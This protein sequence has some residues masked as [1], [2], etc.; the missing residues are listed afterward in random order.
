MRK[1]LLLLLVFLTTNSFSQVSKILFNDI[2]Q[3]RLDNNL[4]LFHNHIIDTSFKDIKMWNGISVIHF[5]HK[6]KKGVDMCDFD[7][8]SSYDRY[9]YYDIIPHLFKDKSFKK[10]IDNKDPKC[11]DISVVYTC[12]YSKAYIKGVKDNF[13][14][15]IVYKDKYIV[16]RTYYVT[17]IILN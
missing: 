2:N 7:A 8:T 3:D 14:N 9:C 12:N 17:V 16:H 6:V 5:K 11:I 10:L 1:I 4:P 13:F 15:R